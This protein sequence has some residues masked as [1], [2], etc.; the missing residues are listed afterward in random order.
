MR[1]NEIE[2]KSILVASKLPA[3]DYVVNP[4]T[5]CTFACAYCYASFMGRFAG[6][7]IEAW[8]KYLSV[9]TNAVDVFR[10]D[11]KR[12]PTKKR[13]STIL[14]SSVTDAWQ[15][16]EKKYKLA[17]GIL[18]TL[19]DDDYPGFISILTK[20][21]LVLRDIE[22]I[23][24]L[25]NKE[26]GITITTT[27]DKIG[28]FM[29]VHAPLAS[30]RLRILATLNAKGVQTYAFVGPLLPHYRYRRDLLE[31]LFRQIHDAGTNILFAEH[32]NTSSYIFKRINPLLEEAD[33]DVQ[34]VY[35]S[36][37]TKE[38][39]AVL[40]DMVMDLAEKYR[41]TIRLGHVIDHNRDKTEL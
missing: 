30:D 4:Y 27:D 6:E 8:G 1:V 7:P 34:K 29:E 13:K 23:G 17:R 2:C 20:S 3:S 18:E 38:H 15:G 31:D 35:Q 16:P 10:R 9:K 11:L 37:R 25:K 21:P 5:G 22:V 12:L 40:S 24:T 32:L 36:A 33:I 19:S 26:V 14:L 41:F 28:R 39:R